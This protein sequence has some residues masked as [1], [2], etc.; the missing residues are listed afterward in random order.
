MAY[1]HEEH[2]VHADLRGVSTRMVLNPLGMLTVYKANV[3]I[4][5]NLSVRL[6]DFG[7][8]QFADST[9]AS[10]GS[11]SGGTLRWMAPELLIE[12]S[13]PNYASDVYAFGCV[14]LEVMSHIA[15]R[16]ALHHRPENFR[17]QV[18]SQSKPFPSMNDAQVVVQVMRR[19]H[20]PHKAMKS[21]EDIPEEI[22]HLIGSCW[23][24]VKL[25]PSMGE[26]VAS[27]FALSKPAGTQ[28]A[29]DEI[30][31]DSVL[32]ARN[33]TAPDSEVVGL[34]QSAFESKLYKGVVLSVQGDLADQI[35]CTMQ[36]VNI[37]NSLYYLRIL[38]QSPP[39][40]LLINI[41]TNRTGRGRG[42][43]TSY[44]A[45]CSSYLQNPARYHHH[46]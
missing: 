21:G 4:D 1:L 25:R 8:S 6:S 15:P 7:L 26:I 17:V 46:C 33:V 9:T 10:K 11:H 39:G 41:H 36:A 2:V 37:L 20:P 27:L 28:E 42:T 32:L 16:C 19:R 22:W 40:R 13:P 30:G 34:I 24:E 44:A 3:L 18:Y 43:S 23:S 31:G 38:T 45:Y 29:G 12:G 5:E 14:C 35:M